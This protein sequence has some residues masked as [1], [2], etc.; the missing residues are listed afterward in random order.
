MRSSQTSTLMSPGKTRTVIVASEAGMGR[1]VSTDS[2]VSSRK[3]GGAGFTVG[4]TGLIV[5][6][7]SETGLVVVVLDEAVVGR[8][9][10][11]GV[12]VASE[13]CAGVVVA[14]E[15]G[16][17][18][19]RTV[20]TSE[21]RVVMGADT[22]TVTASEVIIEAV[23]VGV[24]SANNG[25]STGGVSVSASRELTGFDG[26]PFSDFFRVVSHSAD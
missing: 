7:V 6:V 11:A 17:S 22:G 19:S 10:C 23:C 3:A 21:T 18:P 20:G 26:F 15:T 8:E 25:V 12:V 1:I 16:P 14:S 13:A 4:Q 2:T 5:V 9:A 24:V